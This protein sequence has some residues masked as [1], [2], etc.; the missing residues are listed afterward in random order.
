M[1]FVTRFSDEVMFECRFRLSKPEYEFW[2]E[3]IPYR[4]IIGY[5]SIKGIPDALE[6]D[7]VNYV[8]ITQS[9]S[10]SGNKTVLMVEDIY[11]ALLSF[12]EKDIENMMNGD[13]YDYSDRFKK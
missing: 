8:M 9:T 10:K 4:K 6:I 13:V 3:D 5:A 12:D 1:T 11:G 7:G 2:F